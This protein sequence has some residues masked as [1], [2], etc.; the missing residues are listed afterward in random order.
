MKAGETKGGVAAGFL[1]LAASLKQNL[2]MLITAGSAC[3]RRRLDGFGEKRERVKKKKRRNE[4]IQKNQTLLSV[5]FQEGIMISIRA[6]KRAGKSTKTDRWTKSVKRRR[7]G[8]RGK[9]GNNGI[10]NHTEQEGKYSKPLL[11]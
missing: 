5:L 9:H 3:E 11:R 2:F 7:E 4:R 10:I 6:K 1:G 8:K